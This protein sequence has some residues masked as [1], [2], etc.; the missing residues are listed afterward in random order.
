MTTPLSLQFDYQVLD[1]GIAQDNQNAFVE[2]YADSFEYEAGVNNQEQ[3]SLRFTFNQ[4]AI[5]GQ[6][7]CGSEEISK[8][9]IRFSSIRDQAHAYI[10]VIESMG[11]M[12]YS[13][14]QLPLL[15]SMDTFRRQMHVEMANHIVNTIENNQI[16]IDS[17]EKIE[18]GRNLVEIW[19]EQIGLCE[20]AGTANHR[21]NSFQRF[22]RQF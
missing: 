2:F 14:N 11:Q 1:E 17:D 8:F 21:R 13:A 22:V 7:V 12:G 20:Q 9:D 5:E 10:D 6:I 18:I 16:K 15:E 4:R 19:F 3:Y